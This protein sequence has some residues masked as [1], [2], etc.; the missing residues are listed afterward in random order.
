MQ[1]P[2]RWTVST[3]LSLWISTCRPAFSPQNTLPLVSICRWLLEPHYIGS[4][5][6]KRTKKLKT[7]LSRD[8]WLVW[9]DHV[10]LS[11]E[12]LCLPSPSSLSPRPHALFSLLTLSPPSSL[13][14]RPHSLFSLLALSS[15]S[16]LSPLPPSPQYVQASS[17]CWACSVSCILSTW[18]H[19]PVDSSEYS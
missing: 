6:D 4:V 1:V 10:H 11:S 2:H 14:P 19:C 8:C 17:I 5:L 3:C 16:S 15:P 7:V 13:S 9:F 18:W 12:P